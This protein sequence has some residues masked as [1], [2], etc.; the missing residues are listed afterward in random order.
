MLL[1]IERLD[2]FEIGPQADKSD[3]L[4]GLIAEI[5]QVGTRDARSTHKDLPHSFTETSREFQHH[6]VH[7]GLRLLHR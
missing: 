6:L 3:V 1:Q 2:R 7:G 5:L 4:Q